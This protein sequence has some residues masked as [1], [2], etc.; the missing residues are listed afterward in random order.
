MGS[1]G[2]NMYYCNYYFD[3]GN[4]AETIGLISNPIAQQ[5]VVY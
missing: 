2:K 3:R 4:S 5:P 1:I